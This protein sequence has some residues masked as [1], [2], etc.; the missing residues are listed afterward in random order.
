MAILGNLLDGLVEQLPTALVVLMVSA[1][2]RRQRVRSRS[3]R[4][5]RSEDARGRAAGRE[6]ARGVEPVGQRVEL[7]SSGSESSGGEME[8][9]LDMSRPLSTQLSA[10]VQGL[11]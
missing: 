8:D 9:P 4:T 11:H 7:E 5:N 2:T 3:A 10:D 6:P 1:A